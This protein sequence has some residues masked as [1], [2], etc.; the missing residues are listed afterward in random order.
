MGTA[1]APVNSTQ[2]APKALG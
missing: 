1:V 2:L